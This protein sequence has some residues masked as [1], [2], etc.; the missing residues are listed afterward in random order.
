[1][2]FINR[3][4]KLSWTISKST[5]TL[6]LLFTHFF[7][8]T[9]R[10]HFPSFLDLFSANSL[11]GITFFPSAW[12][13][14]YTGHCH[15]NRSQ[16]PIS[17]GLLLPGGGGSIFVFLSLSAVKKKRTCRRREVKWNSWGKKK[18]FF[19]LTLA[20]IFRAG[21]V[22]TGKCHNSSQGLTFQNVEHSCRLFWTECFLWR[23]D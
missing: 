19:V 3:M 18:T 5:R 17:M 1:M 20:H 2:I 15:R 13:D 23:T 12:Q 8:H 11:I 6:H 21:K 9:K 14:V 4:V 7:A 16:L 10:R 22:L